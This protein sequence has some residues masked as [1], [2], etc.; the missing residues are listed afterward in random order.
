MSPKMVPNFMTPGF[1]KT[2][3]GISPVYKPGQ[4]Q[5]G[6]IFGWGGKGQGSEP[7]L[8]VSY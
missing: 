2:L 5:S 3:P 7:R 1:S 8:P 4:S 6:E